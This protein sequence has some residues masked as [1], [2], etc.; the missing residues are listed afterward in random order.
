[1]Q[2][3]RSVPSPADDDAP[4][5]HL[6]PGRSGVAKWWNGTQWAAREHRYPRVP[7]LVSIRVVW[8]VGP[9]LAGV[10]FL[11]ASMMV[12]VRSSAL[13]WLI[14]AWIASWNLMVAEF[15]RGIGA[16]SV[17]S[18]TPAMIGRAAWVADPAGGHAL[19]YWDGHRYTEWATDL[20]T[21]DAVAP[22]SWATTTDLHTGPQ[23][24]PPA[25]AW[26]RFGRCSAWSGAVALANL[27]N[28][29][30]FAFVPIPC[31]VLALWWG[32]VCARDARL[33]GRPVPG[34]A[35]AGIVLATVTLLLFGPFLALWNAV[36][37]AV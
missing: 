31:A 8:V 28:I 15:V 36:G 20:R 33:V 1:V 32:I 14:I 3:G 30:G 19:R 10:G 23:W 6:V 5:W 11:V 18:H 29:L 24:E 17:S 25:P 27:P 7:R 9:F 2:A 16:G 4:G 13:D 21:E 37:D 12:D 35:V 22:A 26:E 34:G